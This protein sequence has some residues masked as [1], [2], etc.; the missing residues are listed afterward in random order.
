LNVVEVLADKIRGS[1][2]GAVV[3]DSKKKRGLAVD[4]ELSALDSK[5]CRVEGDLAANGKES[6]AEQ[7]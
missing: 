7:H 6:E 5:F 4:R 1:T 2:Q 3:T